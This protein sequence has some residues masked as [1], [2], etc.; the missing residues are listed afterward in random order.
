MLESNFL[1]IHL[2]AIMALD[3]L[4]CF[5]FQGHWKLGTEVDQGDFLT[6]SFGVSYWQQFATLLLA[7]G[8]LEMINTNLAS[9][10]WKLSAGNFLYQ[11][12]HILL[13][14]FQARGYRTVEQFSEDEEISVFL[15]DLSIQ[16]EAV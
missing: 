10:G 11:L 8:P 2:R 3:T 9:W 6:Q 13:F 1:Y 12:A 14:L 16:F 5:N 4:Y 15:S 7:N